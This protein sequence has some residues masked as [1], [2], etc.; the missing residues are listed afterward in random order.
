MYDVLVVGDQQADLTGD[1]RGF[2][3][4]PPDTVE[5][6]QELVEIG[7]P[8]AVVLETAGQYLNY[9]LSL[10]GRGIPGDSKAGRVRN[11]GDN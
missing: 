2:F 1:S 6:A 11:K 4:E 10:V 5:K 9:Q 7:Y 3:F 8:G